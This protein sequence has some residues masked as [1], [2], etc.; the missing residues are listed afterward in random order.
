MIGV[1]KVLK[2]WFG[3]IK[4]EE[5]GWDVFFHANNLVWVAFND[6]REWDK[7]EFEIGEWKNWKKQWVNVK[8]VSEAQDNPGMDD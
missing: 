3:F 7:L 1:I 6:L 4:S 8:L 2:E 5:F